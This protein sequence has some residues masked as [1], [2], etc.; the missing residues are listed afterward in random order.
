[1]IE[2]TLDDLE[3][4]QQRLTA[5]LREGADRPVRRPDEWSAVEVAGHL[6]AS[7]RECFEPRIKAIATGSHPHFDFYSNQGRDFSRD[8]IDS[9]LV[10]WRAT[11]RRIIDFARGLNPEQLART[12]RHDSYGEVT[13]DRYLQIA[14]DHD[15]EH[16]Q[17]LSRG[18]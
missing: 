18:R 3:A 10:E 16:L 4:S 8:P 15:R 12:G 1:M 9:S 6:A 7:E 13:I 11:R 14:L 2:T 17:D 5:A